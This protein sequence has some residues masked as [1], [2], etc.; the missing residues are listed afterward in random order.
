MTAREAARRSRGRP[1]GP[2][3]LLKRMYVFRQDQVYWL[4]VASERTSKTRSELLR[5]A[6]DQYI[7]SGPF[8]EIR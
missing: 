5:V 2:D 8:Q 1:K 6:L 3:T 4:D 7:A